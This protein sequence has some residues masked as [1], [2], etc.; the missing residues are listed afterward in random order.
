[1]SV[2][3]CD[4]GVCELL[5]KSLS[6]VT[7]QLSF[8]TIL[9]QQRL[10]LARSG[11]ASREGLNQMRPHLQQVQQVL[12]PDTTSYL[13]LPN[14]GEERLISRGVIRSNSS[15]PTVNTCL[16]PGLWRGGQLK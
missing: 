12:Q 11:T 14:G 15:L 6:T 1:M 5:I 7:S 9:M 13:R 16:F 2:C 3:V 8:T 10:L 4:S